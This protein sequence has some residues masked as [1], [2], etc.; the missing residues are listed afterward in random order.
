M[1]IQKARIAF[2]K[3]FAVPNGVVFQKWSDGAG[4]VYDK[5]KCVPGSI[6]AAEDFNRYWAGW[7]AALRAVSKKEPV[8]WRRLDTPKTCI[9]ENDE[10]M[11][12]WELDGLPFEPLV[13]KIL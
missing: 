11:R 5:E 7:I 1:D 9:T 8:A 4:Y 13:A 12:G 6:P 2:E 10:I 3:E